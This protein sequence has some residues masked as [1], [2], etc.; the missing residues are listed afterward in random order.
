[1]IELCSHPLFTYYHLSIHP[2]NSLSLI[3]ESR[4]EIVF[5]SNYIPWIITYDIIVK[6]HSFYVLKMIPNE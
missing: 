6:T 3:M 4:E 5:A 1:M 2:Y